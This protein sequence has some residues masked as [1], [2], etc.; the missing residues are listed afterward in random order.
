MVGKGGF[1]PNIKKAMGPNHQRAWELDGGLENIGVGVKE[2]YLPVSK[3]WRTG[4][5]WLGRGV[6]KWVKKRK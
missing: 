4:N 3:R 1:G 6:L 2:V 5:G